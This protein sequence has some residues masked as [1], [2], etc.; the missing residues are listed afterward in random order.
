MQVKD[1]MTTNVIT[2]S[3]E[4]TI[5]EGMQLLLSHNISGLIMIDNNEEVLG[6]VTEKDF[7]VAYDFLGTTDALVKEFA[8][9][10]VVGVK[11][12]DMVDDVSRLLVKSN[13]KRTPVLKD[14]KVVG[15]VS[16]IDIIRSIVSSQE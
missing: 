12:E 13:I 9:Y 2:I 4:A 6:V 3:P 5:A 10:E 15:V 16:R 11:E 8:T 14:N 7:L 1:I